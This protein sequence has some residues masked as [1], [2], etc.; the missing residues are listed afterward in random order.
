MDGLYSEMTKVKS[1]GMC[2]TWRVGNQTRNGWKFEKKWG[3]L[4][5]LSQTFGQDKVVTIFEEREWYGTLPWFEGEMYSLRFLYLNSGSP[6]GGA[7]GGGYGTFREPSLAGRSVSLEVGRFWGFI[8]SS[9][10]IFS[11]LLVCGQNVNSQLPA[12]VAVPYLPCYDWFQSA[13]TVS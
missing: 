9:H 12:P 1:R 10:F 3:N 13:G 11:L 5:E 6:V 8:A 2:L 7:L 4:K